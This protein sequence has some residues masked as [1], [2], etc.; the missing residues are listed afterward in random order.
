M[1]NGRKVAIATMHGKEVVI[2]PH[3]REHLGLIGIT[4]PNINTDSFGTFTR[5]VKRFGDQLETAR[6]KANKAM[7]ILDTDIAISSEGSFGLDPNIPFFQSNFEI[8]LLVD[9]KN[10]T[11]FIGSH[12]TSDTNL[13]ARYVS[14]VEQVLDFANSIG[15]PDHGVILRRN[16]NSKT[17][18]YKDIRT[19][20]D[21]IDTANRMLSRIFTKKIFIE[22][23][24]RAHRNP[25]RM[26]SIEKAVINL[27]DVIKSSS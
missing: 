23:D 19:E 7:Q 26:K 20:K 5:D 3:I 25:T 14:S 21:L 27:I 13:D 9:K 4:T 6:A 11:E 2:E 1:F 16:E 22:T 17:N 12:R 18:I 24:M 10:G 15:F 8:V